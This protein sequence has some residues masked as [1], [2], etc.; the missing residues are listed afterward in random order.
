MNNGTRA[1]VF[2]L[3]ILILFVLSWLSYDHIDNSYLMNEPEHVKTLEATV[4]SLETVIKNQKDADTLLREEI[5]D[6]KSGDSDES[7]EAE[8]IEVETLEDPDAILTV[9]EDE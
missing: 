3:G 8:L 6:L 2:L 5:E 7:E 1:L 9:V 4:D